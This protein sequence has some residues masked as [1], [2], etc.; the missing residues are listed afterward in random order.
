MRD[1]ANG[2]WTR[3]VAVVWVA[4]LIAIMGMS[5]VMPF[6]PLYLSELGVPERQVPLWAGWVGGVN[7]LCAGLF[8]PFW[9]TLA[10]RFGRKPMALRAL[11]GLAV[12]VGLMGYAQNV[13][14]LFFLRMLQGMFGGF[15]AEAIAL[16]GT[17]VPRER[18]GSALGLLQT[19]VVGGHF[20]GPLF[21][22]ELS[23]WVGYRETFRIT[24]AL[25]LA[26]MV[27]ILALVRETRAP[28]GDEE[29]KGVT[30]NVRELLAI[31][32][33]RWM[34]AAVVAAQSGMMLLNP[35]ISLF[36][37]ELVQDPA[38]V[39][40]LAGVVTAAPAVTSFLMAPAWG[41]WGDR[42][43][44]AGVLS[45]ALAGAALLVPWPALAGA[46]WHLLLVRLGMGAFTS[47]LNPSTHSV[48]AHSVDERRT[49][50]AFSL[51]SSAQMFGAC[52]GPFLSGPL[53]ATF[54][55]RILFPITAALLFAAALAA[56]RGSAL[57][58]APAPAK[59]G[60]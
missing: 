35:Q 12:T 18:M 55:I 22:G 57:V 32:Q 26:A 41:R 50:G 45:W 19:A 27:L 2:S 48:A 8:A 6:L 39:N 29:R 52:A 10:D 58:A 17:S 54:G 13:Y 25:L 23:H 34:V 20:V 21:G 53:A 7:F 28:N 47:A 37:K 1:E 46:W 11:V 36:V 16:V 33:L 40:R 31:P 24:G 15:V 30:Q 42:R 51:L 3:N 9:G 49:A 60:A 14:Q 4:V 56:H 38:S 43:G 59:P 44:H 5:L